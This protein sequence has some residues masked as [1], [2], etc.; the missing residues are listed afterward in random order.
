MNLQH[1]S[2]MSLSLAT[3]L[4]MTLSVAHAAP[5][6]NKADIENIDVTP[7]QQVTQE[8]LA[9]IYVLSEVCPSLVSKDQGFDQGYARLA[10]AYMPNEKDPVTALQKRGKARSFKKFVKEARQDAQNAG[11]TKNLQVCKDVAS[12]RA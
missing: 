2:K 8:E 4:F 9:A 11:K 3:A 5:A 7:Q 12:Y 10:Q 1:I 6:K